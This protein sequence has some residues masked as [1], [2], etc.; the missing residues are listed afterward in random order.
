MYIHK[1]E[2][3]KIISNEFDEISNSFP[4]EKKSW[5]SFNEARQETL[6]VLSDKTNIP[7]EFLST[8]LDEEESARIDNEDGSVLIVLDV[9]C[10]N[11]DGT[12]YITNPLII[13][14]NDD[15]FITIDKFK[16]TLLPSFLAKTRSFQPSKHVRLT[17][18]LIYQ[19]S[20]EFIYY[21]RKIDA[22]TKELEYKL[23]TSLKNK[24]LFELMDINKSLV[25]FSTALTANKAVLSKL[26]KSPA[27]KKYEEDFDIMEDTEVELN[28]AIEMCSIYREI[29]AGMMD[30]F[31]SVISNNLNIVMKTL[32]VITI[33]ISIPTLVASIY[34][35]NVNLPLQD[36][37]YGFLIVILCAILLA[38]IAGVIL[39]LFTRN[40][41]RK[42]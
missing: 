40:I 11:E 14:Y 2:N 12:N 6:K 35:M 13:T 9:P 21:L 20:R 34:G 38:I 42:K 32:T 7:Y 31:A 30:A 1:L 33:V 24:E 36:N 41:N 28:Q 4:I 27:Y 39:I 19:L 3:N 29:V 37:P 8:S 17:L 15:Y 18:L 22:H 5:L 16:T 10:L 25:Y 26:L 23:H